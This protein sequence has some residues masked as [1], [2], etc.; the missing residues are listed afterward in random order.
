[1]IGLLD[2]PEGVISDRLVRVET[3]D[4]RLLDCQVLDDTPMCT[5]VGDGHLSRRRE[6]GGQAHTTSAEPW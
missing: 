6:R 4:G 3:E 2:R 5:V 1:M